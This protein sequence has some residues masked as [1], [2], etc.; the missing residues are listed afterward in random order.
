MRNH[1][2][3][4][5]YSIPEFSKATTLSESTIDQAIRSGVLPVKHHGNRLLILATSG[6]RWLKSL[7]DGR[8]NAP[9]QF[10]G[11]RTGRPKGIKKVDGEKP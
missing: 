1:L 5:A 6:E 3:L 10:E 4:L 8:P 2:S 7:P 9:P 11:R